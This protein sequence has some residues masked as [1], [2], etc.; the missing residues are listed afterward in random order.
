MAGG[1]PTPARKPEG[2]EDLWGAQIRAWLRM[3]EVAARIFGNWGYGPI[4]TPIMEQLDVFVH[5]LGQTT[6]VVRKE[7]FRA[8]T[9][10]NLRRVIEEG[11]ES[12]LKAS[13]RLA[14]RPEGTAGFVRAA[15]EH[16][17]VPQGG[18][19]WK[20]WYAGP[21]FRGERVQ[22]GRLREFHQI[23]VECLGSND[24]ALDAEIIVMLMDFYRELGLPE[25]ALRLRLNSMGD[26]DC[27][28]AYR[29]LVRSF[30]LDH[31]DGLCE[32]CVARAD[33]NPLRAFDCKNPGCQAVMADAPA[34]ADHLCDACAE[35][36]SEVKKLLTRAGVAFEEDPTLVRGLDYYT[37]TVFEVE[38]LTG[39][40]SQA[41]IG[42]GGRYDGLV[43]LEGGKPTPGLGFAVG[44]ERI[45]LALEG[46]ALKERD[47]KELKELKKREL[48]QLKARIE[49]EL[50]EL[51]ACKEHD[52]LA[53]DA[54]GVRF[55]GGE[56]ACVY[57]ASA[58]HGPELEDA[59]FDACL[60]LRRSG[61]PTKRDYQGRSLKSQFKQA[62]KA[63]AALCVVIGS[64]ELERGEATLRDMRTHEQ[65]PVALG[66]VAT[67]VAKRLSASASDAGAAGTA[68]DAAPAGSAR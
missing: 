11:G 6:D 37:R 60:A 34:S 57:V 23:G 49:L 3:R 46:I 8:I 30:I 41:A 18:G 16:N 1:R 42:G 66:D 65:S 45:M 40:G 4:E 35:H 13:R 55:G 17:F 53:L 28:P 68:S 12:G 36:Y 64:E 7:M 63:D 31:A 14:L 5:G 38:A 43:E 26:A 52:M 39:M 67:V 21:M 32:E 44:F 25:D 20:A 56:P 51:D 19:C 58:G 22:K 10:T 9:S 61:V 15:I 62:D 33:T 48:N 50:K 29:E 47:L 2:T 59:V 54:L 27:R 24:P